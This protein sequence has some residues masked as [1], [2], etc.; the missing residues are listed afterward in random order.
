MQRKIMLMSERTAD[1]EGL[2]K[3]KV[4]LRRAWLDLTEFWGG[5]WNNGGDVADGV[6]NKTKS[7]RIEQ[8][9]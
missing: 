9:D 4:K 2:T 7:K 6:K 3:T 5:R 8:H 1:E